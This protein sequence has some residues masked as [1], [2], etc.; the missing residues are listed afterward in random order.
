MPAGPLRTRW[1]V[2]IGH[3]TPRRTWA[4][5]IAT[6]RGLG[7]WIGERSGPL[8]TG[9]RARVA[10]SGEPRSGSQRDE[11]HSR[12][13][14]DR[15]VRRFR[16]PPRTPR[17]TS[18]DTSPSG[19]ACGDRVDVIS[20]DV[21]THGV[22]RGATRLGSAS[23]PRRP[24]RP[25]RDRS[26]RARTGLAKQSAAARLAS[27]PW[28]T[29]CHSTDRAP[30]LADRILRHRLLSPERERL[31]R[32]HARD[33]GAFRRDAIAAWGSVGAGSRRRS[34]CR[35]RRS[36]RA[37]ARRPSR[38]PA[39]RRPGASPPAAGRP[40][41]P[42]AWG[43][44]ACEVR[45]TRSSLSKPRLRDRQATR[46]HRLLRL[47]MHSSIEPHCSLASTSTATSATPTDARRPRTPERMGRARSLPYR[48]R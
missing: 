47:S 45:R 22:P 17:F 5:C 24:D 33:S 16:P 30:E 34:R 44:G 19:R 10:R 48:G 28:P 9:Y 4:E 25:G 3:A 38:C 37:R 11:R 27:P 39:T 35:W 8:L 26:G 46:L 29:A 13:Q 36:R 31:N 42:R 1:R 40:R 41:P 7:N 15:A 2:S 12:G 32:H 21:P 6:S 23:A 43:G 14:Q 18:L 20:F